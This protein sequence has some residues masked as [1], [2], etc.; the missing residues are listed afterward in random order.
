MVPNT[1]KTRG[2]IRDSL[3]P[4]SEMEISVTRGGVICDPDA[5]RQTDTRR[6]ATVEVLS[7]ALRLGCS[8]STG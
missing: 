4:N 8:T 7:I 2:E 5:A 3:P 6:A 1:G